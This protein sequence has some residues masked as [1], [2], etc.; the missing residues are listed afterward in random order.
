MGLLLSDSQT[1]KF[2]DK[3]QSQNAEILPII[4]LIKKAKTKTKFENPEFISYYGSFFSSAL[5]NASPTDLSSTIANSTFTTNYDPKSNDINTTHRRRATFQHDNQFEIDEKCQNIAS[6]KATKRIINALKW[7]SLSFTDKKHEI[8]LDKIMENQ[9]NKFLMDDYQHI[10]SEHLFEFKFIRKE[11]NKHI[12]P[13]NINKCVVFERFLALSTN[14]L[15]NCDTKTFC[16]DFMA[17]IHCF[18]IHSKHLL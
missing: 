14:D 12:E 11:L 6:C 3:D 4:E 7:H 9:Y 10:L 13:C 15:S 5:S 1:L 2:R 16:I 8:L 18:L 17:L